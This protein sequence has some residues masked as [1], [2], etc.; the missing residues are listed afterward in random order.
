MLSLLSRSY[1]GA[2]DRTT[3]SITHVSTVGVYT[4]DKARQPAIVQV[5]R[6]FPLPIRRGLTK[7]LITLTLHNHVT[8]QY[9]TCYGHA[10]YMSSVN[11]LSTSVQA[12]ENTKQYTTTAHKRTLFNILLPLPN[13]F[14]KTIHYIHDKLNRL[15]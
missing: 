15:Y 2:A 12:H 4:C 11:P 1:C 14:D 10:V 8:A 7:S 5:S 3:T 13:T 9:H 6:M